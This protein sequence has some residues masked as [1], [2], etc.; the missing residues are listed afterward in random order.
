LSP[1]WRRDARLGRDLVHR[2]GRPGTV[3]HPVG[4]VE[5][6]LTPLFAPALTGGAAD[7]D[8]RRHACGR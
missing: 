7:R 5:Q 2:E 8:R 3:D 1:K 4:R 6:L